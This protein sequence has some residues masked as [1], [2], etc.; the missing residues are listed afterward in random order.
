MAAW[1]AEI[2]RYNWASLSCACNRGGAH[3]TLAVGRLLSGPFSDSE[4]R[5]FESSAIDNHAVI[6]SVAFEPVVPLSSVLT[7]AAAETPDPGVRMA[8]Y[9]ALLDFLSCDSQEPPFAGDEPPLVLECRAIVASA[10]EV[11]YRDLLESQSVLSLFILEYCEVD[12][13]RLHTAFASVRGLLPRPLVWDEY[14]LFRRR[15]EWW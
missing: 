13:D 14:K 5:A 9:K 7:A 2:A 1:T 6:Q 10:K 15:D 4:A 12:E 11:L 8:A 3:L